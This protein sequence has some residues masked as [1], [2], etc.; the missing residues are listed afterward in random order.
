MLIPAPGKLFVAIDLSQ[1][2]TW[3]VAYSAGEGRMKD[4]LK[5]GDIHCQ[6]AS[7]AVYNDALGKDYNDKKHPHWKTIIGKNQRYIGKKTN[8]ASSYGMGEYRFMQTVN[9][10]SDE[11]GITISLAEAKTFLPK[12]HAFY[13][14]IKPWHKSLQHELSNNQRSLTTVYGRQRRFFG[15]WGDPL[16]KEAYAF[17][18]QSTVGDHV[19]GYIQKDVN[20]EGGIKGIFRKFVKDQKEIGICNTSHDSVMLEVPKDSARDIG[21]ECKSLMERPLRINAETF[22]IPAD[23]EI[24]ERW[25]ELEKVA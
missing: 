21:L 25:G 12:W 5:N 11:T 7:L 13:Y 2:E 22:T 10:E 4:A 3:I 19:M 14:C 23:L 6:T 24:G 15:E 16:F 1:A 18:P 20:K 8:H 17:K 9:Q